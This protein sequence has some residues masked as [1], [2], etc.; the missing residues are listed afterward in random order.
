MTHGVD[1]D[2]MAAFRVYRL[3]DEQEK[4]FQQMKPQMVSDR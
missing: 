1:F 3:L 2:A 4:Y